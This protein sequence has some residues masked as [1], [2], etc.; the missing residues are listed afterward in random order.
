MKRFYLKIL[1]PTI[2]TILLFIL[3]I[4][5]IIIP[6]FQQNIMNGKR[7]MIQE[8]TN[9]AL[10]ILLEYET[11]ERNGLLTREE[12]QKYAISRIQYLRYGDESKD[13]FWIT[14]TFPNMIMHPFRADLNGKDLS[15]FTDPHGK[16]LFV[17][18]V[19]TVKKSEHGYV[20]YMW[21]WKDDSL[22]IVPKLSY[23]KI[24]K[25][26][27]WVIGTGIYIEDV[28][29]EISALSRR[30]LWISIG[31]SILT[32]LL[33]FYIIKQSLHIER[34][35]IEAEKDLNESKEKYKTLVEAAT[36]GLLMLIDG[37]ITFVNRVLNKLIGYE[38]AELIHRSLDEIVS[39]NN[40]KDIIDIFLKNAVIKEGQFELNLKKKNGGF[41]EVLVTAST[42]KF[43]GNMVNIFIV[44]DLSIDRSQSF[45]NLDYQKLIGTLNLGF[46]KVR[47]DTKGKILLANE[48]A[49]RILGFESFDELSEVNILKLFTDSEERKNLR[50]TLLSQGYIKNR[51]LTINPKSNKNSIVAMSLVVIESEDPEHL[52]CDGII[53]DITVQE[54]EKTHYNNLIA[55]LKSNSFLL[56]QAIQKYIIPFN[57]VDAD[58]TIDEAVKI[59]SKQKTDCLLVTKNEKDYIGII[60]N[61][62]I[63]KRVLSLKLNLDN[64]VYLIMSSPIVYV[65]CHTSVIDAI[66]I[67]EEKNIN[68]LAVLDETNTISGIFSTKEIYKHFSSSLSLYIDKAGK[69]ETNDELKQCYKAHQLFIKPLIRSDIFIKHITNLTSAFSDS[70]IK[71]I[72][73]LSIS[74]LGEPPADFSFICLGSEG[75]REESLYTDQDN[76]IIYEDVQADKEALVSEYFNQLGE[77]V[78]NS[79]NHVGYSFCKGNVMA[80]NPQWNKPISTWEKYFT[81]WIIT[82]EPQNLLDA[83]IFFDFRNVYGSEE[84]AERLRKMIYALISKQSVFLYHLAYHSFNTKTQSISAGNILSD[85]NAE[86]LDLKASINHLIMFARTYAL[87]NNIWATNTIERLEALKTKHILEKKTVDEI[88][89]VYNYLMKLRFK[90]QINL[91]DKNLPLTNLLNTK[92]LIDIEVSILKKVLSQLPAYQNKLSID[93]RIST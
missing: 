52:V 49:I 14:D 5:L 71:R 82:P 45:S 41:V 38:S 23:V 44:K 87:Q 4:F 7:E 11:D 36:E 80:K 30:M 40:N 1:L 8:L 83:I 27:N 46:F 56:E 60:S 28:K 89:F 78:C 53:E 81:N 62:D 10:S 18:C 59:L 61:S 39:E 19:E 63:Q 92:S 47:I 67:S 16:R 77:M 48:T 12:A 20:N 3:T 50:K 54:K 75:R 55:D 90:N 35:R 66:R 68:H 26:W 64:P 21:Q 58:A 74:K 79:L 76:A 43:F 34:K 29:K 85:G 51:I 33:L 31:I 93:F 24:F 69:A 37:K 84:F 17:E 57:T 15:D 86:M 32:A 72:I 70:V 91:L 9:S 73:D 65:G 88:I 42:A 6:R 25:P 13:Y 22:H 2:L